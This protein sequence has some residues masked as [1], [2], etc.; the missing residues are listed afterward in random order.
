MFKFQIIIEL[1][2]GLVPHRQQAILLTNDEL[3]SWCPLALLGHDELSGRGGV[4]DFTNGSPSKLTH[5]GQNEMP[6]ILQ[7]TYLNEFSWMKIF[8]LQFKFHWSL[9]LGESN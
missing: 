3:V 6:T 4:S 5:S 1:E 2:N 7:M 8:E 9:F